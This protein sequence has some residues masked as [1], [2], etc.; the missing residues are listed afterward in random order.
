MK[1]VVSESLNEFRNFQ[2]ESVN[3]AGIKDVISK[4]KKFVGGMFKK[5]GEFFVSLYNNMIIPV[6]S[7]VNIGV[8][9]KR[10]M[11]K[12]VI[13]VPNAE[14][15]EL[16][17]SLETLNGDEYMIKSTIEEYKET[18]RENKANGGMARYWRSS[19]SETN[20]SESV[21]LHNSLNEDLLKL[22]YSGK[23]KVRNVNTEFLVKRI[24]MQIHNPGLRPPLIWGAPGI[25]KTS[26]TKAVLNSLGDG[27]RVIDVQTSKMT[28][29][30]WTLP[31]IAT[32]MFIDKEGK[33]IP[34]NDAEAQD[35]PKNW[36]PVYKPTGDPE[37]DM[38]RNDIANQGN[39]GIIFLD[40]LLRARE[41]VQ[42]TCLKLVHERII[43]DYKLGS[44]WAIVAA[45]NRLTD[46]P[47]HQFELSPILANRF[48]QYNFVP[49][50]D[51]WI[52]WAKGVK[53]DQRIIDFID[54]NREHFY[55][56]DTE[57]IV[58]TSPRSWEALSYMLNE[59]LKYGDIT[60][61]KA[62]IENIIGGN[63]NPKTTEQFVAFLALI[64]K[65]SPDDLMKVFTDPNKAPKPDKLGNNINTIQAR[66]LIS[67]LCSHIKDKELTP[68][69]FENYIRYFINLGNASIATQ[70]L[71]LL[72]EAH[73][74]IHYH[75][76]EMKGEESEEFSSKFKKGIDM[77][78][79]AFGDI[80][81][82][83]REE[84]MGK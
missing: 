60:F 40:E 44:K 16:E 2:K 11:L 71:L 70:A 49:T 79:K 12:N 51:E 26:I 21:T 4:T 32:K 14:D 41:D 36:L 55:Y 83:K 45:S 48:D 63:I 54:F 29:D 38:R 59:T 81:F 13:Y 74:E 67:A 52:E 76:G 77:F 25:G 33:S 15:I 66:A 1:K 53:I 65:W 42:N 72:T 10:G 73:P 61:T 62:D 57:E 27:Y 30:D 37:E 31:R 7:P 8:L 18:A 64:E 34:L 84:I 22:T 68:Q 78:V 35:V 20:E 58:N 19:I 6:F 80:K 39:G 23:G 47:E 75:I 50:V 43:G 82:A 28:P 9:V 46:D 17:P 5:I 3:E 56:W 24:K 69:Y